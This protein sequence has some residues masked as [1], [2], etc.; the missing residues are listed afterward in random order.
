MWEEPLPPWPPACRLR[1]AWLS[2]SIGVL[3]ANLGK[4]RLELAEKGACTAKRRPLDWQ[5]IRRVLE[6]PVT[7]PSVGFGVD[8]AQEAASA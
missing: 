2:S 7:T 1:L 8:S 6:A 3:V 5:D 4:R